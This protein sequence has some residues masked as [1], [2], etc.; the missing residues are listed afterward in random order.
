MSAAAGSRSRRARV[1]IQVG[2]SSRDIR[3]RGQV[4]VD[5]EVLAPRNGLGVIRAENYDDYSGVL[6]TLGGDGAQV[7]GYVDHAHLQRRRPGNPVHEGREPLAPLLRREPHSLS[8][9]PQP[10]TTPRTV[11]IQ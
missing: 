11:A 8:H 4:Q 6:Q 3:L 1:E 2:A 10:T 9:N 5:G 7:V